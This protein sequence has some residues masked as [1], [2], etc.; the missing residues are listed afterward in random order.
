[1]YISS[2]DH[3]VSAMRMA[4]NFRKKNQGVKSDQLEILL[5]ERTIS[6]YPDETPSSHPDQSCMK[7]KQRFHKF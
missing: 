6:V 4:F 1:M 3:I 2:E 5:S 7:L